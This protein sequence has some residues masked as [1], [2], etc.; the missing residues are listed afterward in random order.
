MFALILY[1]FHFNFMFDFLSRVIIDG[2]GSKT[3]YNGPYQNAGVYYTKANRYIS[4]KVFGLYNVLF[5]FSFEMTLASF[6]VGLNY[7]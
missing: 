5:K 4:G 3:V 6:T 1:V 2:S 7:L